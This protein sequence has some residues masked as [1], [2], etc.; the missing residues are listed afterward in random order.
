MVEVSSP[1]N[2]HPPLPCVSSDKRESWR[3][4]NAA[5]VTKMT[6]P[7]STSVAEALAGR[8]TQDLPHG[9]RRS[10]LTENTHWDFSCIG[11][12][13]GSRIPSRLLTSFC[14]KLLSSLPARRS[15]Y[16]H[17]VSYFIHRGSPVNH[18]TPLLVAKSNHGL[19]KESR[20]A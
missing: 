14:S 1:N 18:I 9:V 8:K 13:L 20:P 11:T 12:A 7:F 3:H 15:K 4:S 16:P 19:P 2:T 17:L 10:I 6:S 5:R